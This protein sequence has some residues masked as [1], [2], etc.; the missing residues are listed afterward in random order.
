M[1]APPANEKFASWSRAMSL[2]SVRPTRSPTGNGWASCFDGLLLTIRMPR[3]GIWRSQE[4][5]RASGRARMTRPKNHKN[6]M[7]PGQKKSLAH[8][9]GGTHTFAAQG[10]SLQGALHRIGE[11]SLYPPASWQTDAFFC[12][13][14]SI[15][16]VLHSLSRFAN[17]HGPWMNDWAQNAV[18]SSYRESRQRTLTKPSIGILRGPPRSGDGHLRDPSY[19]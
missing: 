6:P 11:V 4:V 19:V 14:S 5:T 1:R 10:R 17:C 7:F 16:N 12:H 18:Q 2:S 9:T 15:H 3:R 13:K 8:E